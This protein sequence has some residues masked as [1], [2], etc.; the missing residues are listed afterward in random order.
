MNQKPKLQTDNVNALQNP[1]LPPT[2]LY[3]ITNL[4]LCQENSVFITE[5]IESFHQIKQT[6]LR[7]IV[8]FVLFRANIYAIISNLYDCD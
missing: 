6:L 5:F 8:C 4:Q 2:P 7:N 3:F 1:I